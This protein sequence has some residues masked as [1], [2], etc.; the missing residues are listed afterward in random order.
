MDITISLT[1][2]ELHDLKDRAQ[3]DLW[4]A[5]MGQEPSSI[6]TTLGQ[7]VVAAATA[8]PR[9]V[10]GPAPING[11][12]SAAMEYAGKYFAAKSAAEHLEVQNALLLKAVQQLVQRGAAMQSALI[13]NGLVKLVPPPAR[14]LE[15]EWSQVK[16]SAS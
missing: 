15:G 12:E 13:E 1:E 4:Q 16:V 9:P 8:D 11:S 10:V 2:K 6:L 5:E 7:K 3:V 14:L